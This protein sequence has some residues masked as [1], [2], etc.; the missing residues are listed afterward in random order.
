MIS[1]KY[2]LYIWGDNINIQIIEYFRQIYT[3]EVLLCELWFG[4]PSL[5]AK[6]IVRLDACQTIKYISSELYQNYIEECVT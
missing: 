2:V 1:G 3:G 4:N 6:I 5:L